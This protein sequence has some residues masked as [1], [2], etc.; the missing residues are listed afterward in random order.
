VVYV[1]VGGDGEHTPPA[2]GPIFRNFHVQQEET[3][4]RQ[5][6]P[7]REVPRPIHVPAPPIPK[8]PFIPIPST[9]PALPKPDPETKSAEEDEE[10][11]V[12][13]LNLGQ[14]NTPITGGILGI[15]RSS[16]KKPKYKDTTEFFRNAG[17]P[18]LQIVAESLGV[19][20]WQSLNKAALKA[21]LLQHYLPEVKGYLLDHMLILN[22]S[23]LP[24]LDRLI[25]QFLTLSAVW[26]SICLKHF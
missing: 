18:D 11:P 5:P 9:P 26:L 23:L 4:R 14:H 21:S 15:L 6:A 7:H 22:L 24:C 2:L 17:K 12:P 19:P 3:P 8:S 20:H 1:H 16:Q 13:P 25:S 10:R